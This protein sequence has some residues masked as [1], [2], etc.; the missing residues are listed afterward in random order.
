MTMKQ[1]IEALEKRIAE[2]EA[3]LAPVASEQEAKEERPDWVPDTAYKDASGLWRNGRGEYIRPPD[4][5][6]DEER[7]AERIATDKTRTAEVK[8][9]QS[10]DDEGNPLPAGVWRDPC[11]IFRYGREGKEVRLVEEEREA[12]RRIDAG[13]AEEQRE[14]RRE[15][16]RIWG[17][18]GK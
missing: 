7:L 2:L 15:Q 17:R 12:R 8:R 9:Y 16:D 6:T 13:L 10:H 14:V 4:A 18:K 3:K 1:Q 5:P 11:G